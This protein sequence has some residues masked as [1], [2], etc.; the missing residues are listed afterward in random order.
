MGG[1]TSPHILP[2]NRVD[3]ADRQVPYIYG[4][5]QL[6]QYLFPDTPTRSAKSQECKSSKCC[7]L[8]L[9]VYTFT[10]YISY[11]IFVFRIS[12][13]LEHN[14]EHITHHRS[15]ITDDHSAWNT[16]DSFAVVIEDEHATPQFSSSVAALSSMVL[17]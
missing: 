3:A 16:F 14:S 15:Q 2:L 4:T 9:E 11:F 12:C 6:L 13:P 7:F 17:L 8:E 5:I 10:T 1:S